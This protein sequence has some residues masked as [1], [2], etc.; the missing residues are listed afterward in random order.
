MVNLGAGLAGFPPTPM[1]PHLVFSML[2]R[3]RH[4]RRLEDGCSPYWEQVLGRSARAFRDGFVTQ[5]L[6]REATDVE[7]LAATHSVPQLKAL[8]QARGLPVSGRK[9]ALAA[10]ILAA[11]AAPPAMAERWYTLTEAGRS[12]YQ[13]E[14]A[15]RAAAREVAWAEVA[16]QVT[17][18][19]LREALRRVDAYVGASSVEALL[20]P[21]PLAITIPDADRLK[22]AAWV[23]ANVPALLQ[24]LP[25]ATLARCRM[26]TVLELLGFPGALDGLPRKTATG[27]GEWEACR[28]WELAATSLRERQRLLRIHGSGTGE[29]LSV[30]DAHR[31]PACAAASGRTMPIGKLP[32]LPHPKCT[33]P[34]GCRCVQTLSVD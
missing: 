13:R 23:L 1:H 9:D 4:P 18:G 14:G 17:A 10:R 27:F 29:L 12:R 19:N 32:P 25:A 33:S 31:C 11:P 26:A 22:D 24:Q 20:P 5:G 34:M 30:N 15:A 28:M 2:H 21:S 6:L 16:Q 7:N 8:A 3:F